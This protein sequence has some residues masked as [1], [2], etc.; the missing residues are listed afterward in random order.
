MRLLP[1]KERSGTK[2]HDSKRHEMFS[3][4]FSGK[5]REGGD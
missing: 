1:E 3:I 5:V 2:G 4:A